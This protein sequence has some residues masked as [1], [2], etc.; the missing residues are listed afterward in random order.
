MLPMDRRKMAI[1]GGPQPPPINF[2]S[3]PSPFSTTA[4]N[5][6][7]FFP[8]LHRKENPRTDLKSEKPKR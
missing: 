5:N 2:K 8:F 1:S 3:S 6:P 7:T 4:V